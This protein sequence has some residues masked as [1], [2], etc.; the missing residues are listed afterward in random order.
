[1]KKYALIAFQLTII[2]I[3]W[4]ILTWMLFDAMPSLA[5]D[6]RSTGT[7]VDIVMPGDRPIKV[8][9]STLSGGD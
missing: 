2:A 8:P 3:G 6:S 9:C 1:M 4:F 5:Q 7:V